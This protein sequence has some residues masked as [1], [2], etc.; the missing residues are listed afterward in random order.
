AEVSNLENQVKQNADARDRVTQQLQQLAQSL[1][2][3]VNSSEVLQQ[4]LAQLNNEL[5]A[6]TSLEQ[7]SQQSLDELKLTLPEKQAVLRTANEGMQNS[8]QILQD[9]K[10]KIQLES[11]GIHYLEQNI[12][13]NTQRIRRF[14]SDFANLAIPDEA[15]LENS[16]IALNQAQQNVLEI[17]Q[18]VQKFAAD[19]SAMQLA[20]NQLRDQ[21][22]Q[23]QR[24]F[25]QAETEFLTLQKMQQSLNA[26]GKLDSWLQEKGLKNNVRLWQKIKVDQAWNMALEAVLG[27]KLN[28]LIA[29]KA[30]VYDRP[31]G[32]LVM[33]YSTTDQQTNSKRQLDLI[34]LI[35]VIQADND[36]QPILEDWLAGV[37]L[38]SADN[39][40]NSHDRNKVIAALNFGEILVNQQGDIFS[41]HSVI[42]HGENSQLSGVL[43]RQAQLEQLQNKLPDLQTALQTITASVKDAEHQLLQSREEQQQHSQQLRYA[44]Q[45]QHQ[46][47]LE[48][49]KLQQVRQSALERE[50]NIQADMANSKARLAEL[51]SAKTLRQDALIALTTHANALELTKNNHDSAR[52]QAEH[53]FFSVRDKLQITEKK[54]QE[55]YFNIKIINNKI[56][57]INNKINVNNEEKIAIELRKNESEQILVLTPMATLK[58][59]LVEA[60]NSKQLR[61]TVLASARNDLVE[62]EQVLQNV[63]RMRMQIEQQLH[64]LRDSL[65]QS[66]LNE[67]QVRLTFEQCQ[68]GLIENGQNEL[69]L[70][71]GLLATTKTSDL[72]R[73]LNQIQQEITDLGAVNLAAIQE[74]S[75]ETERKSYL[76][77]QMQ[78]L[79]QAS[80]TLEDAIRKIDR[81]TREKLM[82]TFNTAN[83]HFGELFATLF[84]GGQARLELLGDEILDTGLQVFAQP[85]GKKNT[86]IQLLSGGEKALTALALVFALFRLNPAPFCLMDEVDAPLDDTNTERFCH[87]VKKMSEKTQFLFVSHN[88]I[89][90]EMAQQLIGVTMQESGV[91]RI[92]DVDIEAAMSLST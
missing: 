36:L 77:S 76:D 37:Y 66:R 55:I 83:Q 73:K 15:Q 91:S 75:M 33:G 21:Q 2:R 86:T 22:N 11:S 5:Q 92:V 63:E 52:K 47:Q 20:I 10:Q 23:A 42:F 80:E 24:S 72:V 78:D 45:A 34:P 65:E 62:K 32:F 74:L 19:E 35:N 82:H 25:N 9:T 56:I 87:M 54:Y 29:D 39:E 53:V 61:E 3:N 4:N 18:L 90:M 89:T 27:A 59:N 81:E 57:E 84:G 41:K 68:A 28:A 85:P 49:S 88:K 30:A 79:H 38:L 64:P 1:E 58:A 12:L 70:A 26:A 46:L 31:P 48:L 16:K 6:A 43:E 44:T 8:Q 7:Q 67:Q 40:K 69:E 14:E 60:L 17:E 50:K 13:E 51:V 71:A